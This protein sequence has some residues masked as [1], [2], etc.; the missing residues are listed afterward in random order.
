MRMRKTT[1]F[2]KIPKNMR[3]FDVSSGGLSVP[4]CAATTSEPVDEGSTSAAERDEEAISYLPAETQAQ[5]GE[6]ESCPMLRVY[7]EDRVC[8]NK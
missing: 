4:T 7:Y 6:T 8:M 2:L 1:Y 3:N 5:Y